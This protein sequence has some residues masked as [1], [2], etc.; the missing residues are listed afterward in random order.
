MLLI[1]S[2]TDFKV[3]GLPY[4]GVPILVNSEM[5][6]VLPV[7][8]F[9]IY[10]LVQNGR[11]QSLK[12]IQSYANSLYDFFSFLEANNLSWDQPFKSK[13]L[14]EVSVVALYR[15][16]SVSLP[17]KA[18][19]RTSTINTR[20]AAI[21][22]FYVYCHKA[23][24]I[25]F[26]P[27]NEARNASR[28]D[29]LDF[30][31]HTRTAREAFTSNLR[32]KSFKQPPKVLSLNQAKDL[33]KAISNET[34]SLIVKLAITT[35]M[36]RDE[37]TSFQREYVFKPSVAQLSRRLP[38]DLNPSPG[39]QRT[40]GSRPRTIY[41]PGPLM[42][43]LYEYTRFG[44]GVRRYRKVEHASQNPRRFL[45]LTDN[46]DAFSE[47]ALNTLLSRLF[48]GGKMSFLVTPHMLRHTFAT[49]ELYAEAQLRDMAH[50][51][52]W[53][54]DRL[55]HSSIQTTMVYIHC[56]EQ[57]EDHELHQY[58]RELMQLGDE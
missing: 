21:Q 52:A 45:F 26:L 32:L 10:Q 43:E 11:I 27:W 4:A 33:L 58:Q 48:L 23:K 51:L 40:K 14:T 3:N 38:I 18:A 8:R 28:H 22:Q 6:V 12:T 39:G 31:R 15:N 49:I 35:G 5:Q 30:L 20:L 7:L 24:I 9:V 34:L 53:V 13:K 54:R 44:E 55:G 17:G 57:L 47:R 50:A 56:I 36:R 1:K 37:L 19:L 25:G 2:T 46:G 41:V 16:W 29:S 42:M